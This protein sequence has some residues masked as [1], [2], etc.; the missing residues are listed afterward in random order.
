MPNTPTPRPNPLGEF[1]SYNYQISLYMITPDAYQAFMAAGR[2][3]IQGVANASGAR[4][5]LLV[6]QS[7]GINNN[8]PRAN[9]FN[10]DYYIED[11]KI[12][13]YAAPAATGTSSNTT[14]I[15]FNI[16]EPYGFSFIN[17]LKKA[18]DQINAASRTPNI[19]EQKNPTRQFFI[20][21]VRFLGYGINGG[22][23]TGQEPFAG[24]I[25]DQGVNEN[26][27]IFENFFDLTLNSVK[28]K[29]DGKM[30]T[31]Q[32]TG[33]AVA[34]GSVYGTKRGLVDT[35]V[36]IAA[37][38]VE[39]ALNDLMD[40]INQQQRLVTKSEPSDNQQPLN[41]Y[42]ISYA[43]DPGAIELI[44]KAKIVTQADLDK[45]KFDMSKSQNTAEVTPAA[46]S[47]AVPN[48]EKRQIQVKNGSVTL[49]VISQIIAQS[50]Y[51]TDAMKVVYTASLSPSPGTN[52][53]DTQTP[54]NETV[55]KWYNI[56]TRITNTRYNTQ[57]SDYTH[58]IEYVIQPYDTPVTN[59]GYVSKTSKYYGPHKRYEFWYTGK[60]KEIIHFEQSLDNSYYMV[61]LQ[62]KPGD[63]GVGHGGPVNI[64]SVPNRPQDGNRQNAQG[65]RM[66]AQNSYVTSL[67]DPNGWASA[68]MTILG[69]PDYLMNND[70][71][72]VN[73]VYNQF[74][75]SNGHTINANGGQVFIEINFK[76]AVDY[77][78][79]LDSGES[80]DTG[81]MN[82][83][84]SIQFWPYPPEVQA[85]VDSRGG[86][87]IYQLIKINH[88]FKNGK[89]T[90]ELDLK[91]CGF[92]DAT[93][94]ANNK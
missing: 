12:V 72:G 30:T 53:P 66:E 58:D 78:Y 71:P 18:M 48:T 17:N 39:E 80:T 64:P 67:V 27:G 89:F 16:V 84:G 51:M 81:L 63:N 56:S 29:L 93:P 57:I 77:N 45:A 24:G 55:I 4:G 15:T 10:F 1:A 90:Q 79:N 22:V 7:G 32:C 25:L 74:Y 40:K 65:N 23:M 86:G 70:P 38:T 31:Y 49:Q 62:P 68:K 83:N 87:I 28:F 75:G 91:Q 9:G 19:K 47:R 6:A 33:T 2:K 94:P 69:D 50:S 85:S 13:N 46:G 61:A 73:S 3:N 14:D 60:S 8:F 44:K 54:P 26:S 52:K 11:L 59:S 36:P 35:G 20:L 37:S 21:G 82:I 88:L 5:A 76:E 92:G 42:K 34:E 43:G 41:S